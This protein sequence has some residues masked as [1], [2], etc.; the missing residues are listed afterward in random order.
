MTHAI[1]YSHSFPLPW[2][3][4]REDRKKLQAWLMWVLLGVFIVGAPMPWLP[5]P[6]IEREEL[7]QLPP[8][9]ARI[10]MEKV[11]PVIPPP[12]PP[13]EV[14]EE[15]KPKAEEKPVEEIT[16]KPEP[17]VAD[18]KE[19]AALS[20]L[21]AFKDAFA[22][23][24]D[25]V[26]MSK[27]QDTGAIQRGSGEAAS[28]DR[29]ILTSKH[30]TRSAGVNVSALSRETGGVALSGRQTTKVNVP[31]GSKGTGRVRVPR[32]V[33]HRGRSIEEIRRVFDAN[34]GA[35]FAIYNRALRRD[36]MLQ[37]RVVLELVIDPNGQVIE[38]KVVAT[39][40]V[41]DVLVSK[42]VNRV[43]LFDFGE[44]DVSTTTINYPVHFLPT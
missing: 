40:L 22:D 17:T 39:E 20:G 24:R 25:A 34:K 35:I 21:L 41:D 7:E 4:G 36:P 8:Q 30:G 26:D 42:I 32:T 33:D 10:L 15:A 31:V 44:R 11:E 2:D 9:L 27:L 37:G 28:I 14:K 3:V 23:M 1:A 29:A 13:P 16:V 19:R 12:P 43:R 5:L 18:A 6:E 38:C